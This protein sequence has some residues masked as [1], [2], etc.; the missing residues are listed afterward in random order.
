MSNKEEILDNI[1]SSLEDDNADIDIHI[2]TLKSYLL[3]SGNKI[4]E[5]DTS[6]LVQNNRE[7]RKRMQSYF[8]KR[9]VIVS[10]KK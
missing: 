9:G 5:I 4:V 7:G 10:F 1:Y 2:K 8:K 3:K 6:R